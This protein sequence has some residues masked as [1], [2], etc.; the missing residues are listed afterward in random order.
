MASG[1]RNGPTGDGSSAGWTALTILLAGC[2]LLFLGYATLAGRGLWDDGAF[3]LLRMAERHTVI[4]PEPP[5]WIGYLLIEWPVLLALEAGLRPLP[6]LGILF[7]FGMLWLAP[8]TLGLCWLLLPAGRKELF[9]FPLLSL[10]LGW[11]ASAFFAMG[12]AQVIALWFWPALFATLHLP[13]ANNRQVALLS[14]L[15][16]PML[17]MHEAMSYLGLL[18]AGAAIWRLRRAAPGPA[19]IGLA[20][21]AICFVLGAGIAAWYILHPA[22]P[23]NRAYFMQAVYRL[24]FLSAGDLRINWPAAIG[25]VGGGLLW[26]SW[27]R[28]DAVARHLAVWLPPAA[29]LFAAAGL[30]PIL[31]PEQFA[32]VTQTNARAWAVLVP[33]GLALLML[34]RESGRLPLPLDSHQW[35]GI[36]AGLAAAQITWQICATMQWAGYV[37]LFRR[38]L[39]GRPGLVRHEDT[40]LAEASLG[41]Q[42]LAPLVTGWT[43]TSMSIVLAP[44]GRVAAIVAA[45]EGIAW[46]P[47]DPLRPE[48]LPRVEGVDYAP[49]LAAIR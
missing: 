29:L 42:A 36:I 6:L 41:T 48:Q 8:L 47:F 31:L 19:R 25:L 35:R 18:L 27:K 26:W 24:R 44:Q 45:P 34:A 14:L 28:P 39:A 20:L 2:F 1:Q 17:L 3:F 40:L 12:T 46:Q 16:G 9:L 38:E 4:S 11:M 23:P 7:T 10:L 33:A 32:P 21:A 30:A 43:N 49:Y 37:D 13:L 15:A 22:I 5:R